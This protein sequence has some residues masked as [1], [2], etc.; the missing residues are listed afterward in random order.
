MI[1]ES[2]M[3]QALANSQVCAYYEGIL[4]K[5]TAQ[6]TGV[7]TWPLALDDMVRLFEK[8]RMKGF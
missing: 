6:R 2:G 1:I 3:G 5:L 4:G 8:E 7:G